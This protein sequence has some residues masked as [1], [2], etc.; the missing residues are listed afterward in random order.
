VLDDETASL[1]ESKIAAAIAGRSLT[2]LERV[3]RT[4][5]GA[6]V[7]ELRDLASPGKLAPVSLSVAAGEIIGIA[8]MLGSGRSELL[9]AIFGADEG[10]R[11]TVLLNGTPVGR[12][13]EEAVAAGIAL[14]PEDRGT[15]GF[16]PAMTIA[17]NIA[18]P[19]NGLAISRARERKA[20]A[21]AIERLAIKASGP[22]AL[23]SELSG[24]NAQKVV[25]AKWL[26]PETRVLLL[27]EPTAGIDIGARTDILRLIRGLAD[28]GLPVL[29]VSS[30]FEELL[31]V[32]DRILVMRDGAAVAEADPAKID[33]AGLIQLASGTQT[34]M[35]A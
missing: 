15:Q 8:G 24:G 35:A 30:E 5:S 16:V 33:E 3:E 9:H 17:E 21:A 14:V 25:I 4:N 13:P 31:G 29:L 1:D 10:A 34:G 27:D 2:A 18:L 32:A 7:L 11:G 22:E 6:T 28:Q 12:S 26:T 23:V 20:A 19:R